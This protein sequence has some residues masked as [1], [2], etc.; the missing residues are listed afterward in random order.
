MRAPLI[1]YNPTDGL[2]RRTGVCLNMIVKDE[3]PVIERLLRSVRSAI[4]Y[5]VIVDTGSSDGTP[6]LIHRLARDLNLPGEIHFRDW[7]NFGHN[8]QQALELAL[9]ADKCDWL[10]LIDADQE[11]VCPNPGFF[12]RLEPGFSYW[13]AIHSN[14]MRGMLPNLIDVRHAQWEW[15]DPL[16][17]YIKFLGGSDHRK[18]TDQAWILFHQGEGVR[19]R[20]LTK[21]EKFL[22]DAVL[23]EAAVKEKPQNPRYRFYLAQSYRDAGEPLQAFKNYDRRSRMVG[24]HDEETYEAQYEKARLAIGIGHGQ[25]VVIPEIIRAYRIRPTRAEPLWLLARYCRSHGFFADG[26]QCAQ[27]GIRIPYPEDVLT[28]NKAVYDWRLLHE[29]ACC[30]HAIGRFGEAKIAL[31]KILDKR[32]YP[33]EERET[34]NTLLTGTGIAEAAHRTIH[35]GLYQLL[36]R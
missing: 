2:Q 14:E 13:L 34:I 27:I 28:V 16:H 20:G 30:A 17:E 11:L 3:T 5:F 21:R 33:P 9:A 8:R 23:L 7:V 35:N 6:D 15:Q 24:G 19:S 12:E 31:K 1:T 25:E 4:D 29:Y 26:Y 10:L 32:T 22:R 36:D 18:H